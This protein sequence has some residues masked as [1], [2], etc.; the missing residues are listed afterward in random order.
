MVISLQ[1]DILFEYLLENSQDIIT[2]TDL[3][4]NYIFISRAFLKTYNLFHSSQV[5]GKNMK[6]I[7][8][9]ECFLK[10]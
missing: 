2:L 10:T 7:I 8:P 9:T 3:N 5:I 6:N 1:K 4:L